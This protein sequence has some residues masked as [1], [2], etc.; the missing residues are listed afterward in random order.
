M[1]VVRHRN[2]LVLALLTIS[3]VSALSAAV[4][5]Q[6]GQA[7]P[8]TAVSII[9]LISKP[10]AYDGK[11][12][13]ITGF[14]R[15]EFEGNSIYLHE[16]DYRNGLY[17]NGMWLS[18]EERKELNN[19]YAL[20]EGSFNAGNKGHLGLWSGSIENVSRAIPWPPTR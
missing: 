5:T 11:R 18:M 8:I 17:K 2:V 16:E 9:Q 6:G 20:I 19:R 15:F 3:A 12:V 1:K 7:P 13:S 10:E 4:L 14:V